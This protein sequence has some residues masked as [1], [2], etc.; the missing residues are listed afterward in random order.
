MNTSIILLDKYKKACSIE[1][2]NACAVAL[3]VSRQAVSKW[4]H[5]ENHPEVDVIER[6]CEATS[7]P[8]AH[9][10]H[11]I[12]ADR[13]RSPAAR[14]AWLR[15]AQ[16]AASIIAVYT[17]IRFGANAHEMMAFAPFA[18]IHYAKSWTGPVRPP[19]P[20]LRALWCLLWAV[21]A[22]L[23][24]GHVAGFGWSVPKV[25]GNCAMRAC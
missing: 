15:L 7:E 5:G 4:R 24:V 19:E 1:S 2:D 17:A 3:G 21:L 10:V 18:C 8:F 9:W 22:A 16:V 13:A 6:M 23:L 20:L 12:E 14:K 11:M 25:S